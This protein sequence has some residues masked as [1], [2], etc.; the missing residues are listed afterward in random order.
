MLGIVPF[1]LLLQL[2][3][4]AKASPAASIVFDAAH[5]TITQHAHLCQREV[6]ASIVGYYYMT[7]DSGSTV[8]EQ[9]H[10]SLP[11]TESALTLIIA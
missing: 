2:F 3:A 1:A 10:H 11:Y 6:D 5:P 8:G 7:D 9:N 4:H